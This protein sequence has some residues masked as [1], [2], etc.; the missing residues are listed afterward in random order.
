MVSLLDIKNN[1]GLLKL[2]TKQKYF[3]CK[4]FEEP[5]ILFKDILF[6]VYDYK[7]N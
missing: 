3:L 5:C 7:S 4:I 2:F 6:Q 1:A